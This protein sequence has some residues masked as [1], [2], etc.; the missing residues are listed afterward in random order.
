MADL[1]LPATFL[2]FLPVAP[3]ALEIPAR[4]AADPVAD[5]LGLADLFPGGFVDEPA[6]LSCLSGILLLR[7]AFARSHE[8][9]QDLDTAEGRYWH[10]I[11]HRRE[12]DPANA[13]YWMAR[14]GSH[15]VHLRL[16]E[17]LAGGSGSG[18]ASPSP[19]A[20][21]LGRDGRWDPVRFIAACNARGMTAGA[22]RR[23]EAIQMRE[24]TL[25]LAHGARLATG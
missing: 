14:V 2:P 7:D 3:V 5:R 11:L 19:D 10:G 13:R 21:L 1:T 18:D 8:V 6:A 12:P 16:A 17:E 20:S 9:C 24:A 15:P 22:R 23:L 25:L 4:A